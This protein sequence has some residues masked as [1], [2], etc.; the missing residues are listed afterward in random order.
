MRFFHLAMMHWAFTICQRLCGTAVTRE[1]IGL[2]K[3]EW[4]DSQP[5]TIFPIGDFPSLS[6][7]VLWTSLQN[8]ISL[9]WLRNY[10]LLW[11]LS[12]YLLTYWQCD[13]HTGKKRKKDKLIQWFQYCSG[14]LSAYTFQL[15]GPGSQESKCDPYTVAIN[16]N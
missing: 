4:S 6:W 3:I 14:L 15:Y 1:V 12:E 11:S 9:V 8:P 5:M 2:L 10:D 13:C 7:K 16:G